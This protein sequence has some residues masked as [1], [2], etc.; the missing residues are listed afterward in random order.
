MKQSESSLTETAAGVEITREALDGM[1]FT[2]T[3]TERMSKSMNIGLMTVEFMGNILMGCHYEIGVSFIELSHIRTLPALRRLIRALFGDDALPRRELSSITDEEAIHLSY[4][5]HCIDFGIRTT[6]RHG[7]GLCVAE[8]PEFG[9]IPEQLLLIDWK[10]D[11]I[12]AEGKFLKYIY[13]D[14]LDMD[15]HLPAFHGGHDESHT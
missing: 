15:F 2:R 9:G 12:H 11:N 13:A 6:V 1:G 7:W 4:H 14:L 3:G 5:E 10:N 8:L